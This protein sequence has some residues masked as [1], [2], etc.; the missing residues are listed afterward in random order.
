MK[1]FVATHEGI[2]LAV[3]VG[4]TTIDLTAAKPNEY[5]LLNPEK[6]IGKCFFVE[7]YVNS[8]CFVDSKKTTGGNNRYIRNDKVLRCDNFLSINNNNAGNYIY[9]TKGVFIDA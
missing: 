9:V 1:I 4:M 6:L 2:S 5:G 3:G 8:P 7:V